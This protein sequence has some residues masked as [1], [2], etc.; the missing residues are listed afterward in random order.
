MR[1]ILLD[2]PGP[3]ESLRL[4]EI[5]EPLPHIGR[6][7]VAVRR[8]G[9]NPV[10][11]KICASGHPDWRYPHVPGLDIA[12]TLM[13]PA[14]DM[15]VG[16][17]VVLHANLAA[18]GGLAEVAL[19]RPEALAK[20][21]DDVSF[22]AAAALP[23]AGL[24]ALQGLARLNAGPGRT[25]VVHGASGAVG[26]LAV[27]I[28]ELAGARVI[29]IAHADRHE[30]LL[31]LRPHH[32]M[33]DG[34]DLAD[35]IRAVNDGR[36]A[37]IV[38]DT[39]S[40]A[41]ATQALDQLCHGG[42]LACIAGMAD[43]SGLPGFGKALTVTEIAVG[44]AY[45]PEG[46]ARAIASLGA[47]CHMLASMPLLPGIAETLPLDDAPQALARVRD[48]TAGGKIIVAVTA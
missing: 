6:V 42:G 20:I 10:D 15:P 3:A 17:R 18:R 37:D 8:V 41:H 26:R 24:A 12:G 38:V 34:P 32:V 7:R 30:S 23:C 36:L 19:V 11:W 9:L 40:A 16:T 5:A 46:D 44:A 45:G 39:V 33:E 2:Q 43:I 48:R 31:P 28:A 14:T 1:A 27:Q 25:V 29:A 22:D 4:G 13:D 47:G 21:P 35:R